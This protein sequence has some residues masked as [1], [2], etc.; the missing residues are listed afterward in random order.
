MMFGTR[1]KAWPISCRNADI[2]TAPAEK[3]VPIPTKPSTAPFVWI[4][5]IFAT[6][7]L[8][9]K[10]DWPLMLVPAGK[11]VPL[12]KPGWAKGQQI[13]S[14]LLVSEEVPKVDTSLGN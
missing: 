2:R 10:F 11:L 4:A 3:P 14:Q 9:K 12:K 13:S 1:A 5:K 8:T 6:L 7:E